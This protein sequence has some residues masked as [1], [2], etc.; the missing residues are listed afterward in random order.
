M[1]PVNRTLRARND[2][3]RVKKTA[4]PHRS[5]SFTLLVNNRKDSDPTKFGIIVSNNVDKR[6]V[7]RNRI[8]R[9]MREVFRR[10]MNYLPN[11]F[12]LLLVAGEGMTRMTTEEMMKEAREFLDNTP[13]T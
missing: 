1:L 6:A 9:A 12:D 8:K 13:L 4:K 2:F 11:G 3:D 7:H 5:K 10:A